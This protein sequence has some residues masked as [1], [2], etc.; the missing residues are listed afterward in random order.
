MRK[1]TKSIKLIQRQIDRARKEDVMVILHPDTAEF[2]VDCARA[3]EVA[4][5]L[6]KRCERRMTDR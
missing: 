5:Q 1:P 2:L 4:R 3:M 6:T